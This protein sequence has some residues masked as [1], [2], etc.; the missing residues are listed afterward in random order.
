MI[1]TDRNMPRTPNGTY[2]VAY[3]VNLTSRAMARLDHIAATRAVPKMEFI[4]T[5]I[6]RLLD[7]TEGAVQKPGAAPVGLP[8]VKKAV[9]ALTAVG[10][11][12]R[13]P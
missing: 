4:R 11:A 3:T 10:S 12:G 7:E 13:R 8:P 2:P 5:A 1:C 6:E 9:P